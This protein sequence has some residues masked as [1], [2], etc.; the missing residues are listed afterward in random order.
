MHPC[1]TPLPIETIL[2]PYSVLTVTY[3]PQ[4]GQSSA[5]THLFL[6]ESPKA[7]TIHRANSLTVVYKTQTNLPLFLLTFLKI[8]ILKLT[9]K[10]FFFFLGKWRIALESGMHRA[11]V[12]TQL[13]RVGTSSF[14]LPHTVK[15]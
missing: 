5:E 8:D 14:I 4:S 11:S 3:H 6:S 13:S 9:G 7:F 15:L 1:L 2:S 12:Y 10:T